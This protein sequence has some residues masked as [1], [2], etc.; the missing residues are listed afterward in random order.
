MGAETANGMVAST[1][2]EPW[3]TYGP[4]RSQ[5]VAFAAAVA[6]GTFHTQGQLS[7]STSSLAMQKN[8]SAEVNFCRLKAIRLLELT[9]SGP[10]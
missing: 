2:D 10:V 6:A 5:C 9:M 7:A 3:A 8:K 4:L 1:A